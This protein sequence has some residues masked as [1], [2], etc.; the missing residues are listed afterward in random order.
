MNVTRHRCGMGV[1]PDHTVISHL[2]LCHL[3][4]L[5][6]LH[7]VTLPSCYR[8]QFTSVL[9]YFPALYR[10]PT[11][12]FHWSIPSSPS[13]LRL[14]SPVSLHFHLRV[15]PPPYCLHSF[16]PT[17]QGQIQSLP[18]SHFSH[19]F[20]QFWLPAFYPIPYS[21]CF[22]SLLFCT[23]ELQMGGEEWEVESAARNLVSY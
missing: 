14:S 5:K 22:P 20:C 15:L 6:I 21:H 23:C 18:H 8:P 17:E 9:P 12:P 16:C 7:S 19:S 10:P 13:W 11:Q 3:P 1:S 2:S 4:S